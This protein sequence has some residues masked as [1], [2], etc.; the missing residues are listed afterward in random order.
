MTA[1]SEA[2]E[3]TQASAR[4]S[5]LLPRSH[6]D[7]RHLPLL[8]QTEQPLIV[9][10]AHLTTPLDDLVDWSPTESTGAAGGIRTHDHRITSAALYQL[11]YGSKG[12]PRSI[13]VK[14]LEEQLPFRLHAAMLRRLCGIRGWSGAAGERPPTVSRSG[15]PAARRPTSAT[16]GTKP[17]GGR[18]RW[19][20]SC[21]PARQRPGGHRRRER[22]RG[23]APSA[24][25]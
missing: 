16:G 14:R 13:S 15:L 20:P 8:A 12:T 21:D 19:S 4:W 22:L 7:R 5:L 17:A 25:R 9:L 18:H 1:G 24:T 10:V 23:S 2:V 6:S 3:S 11:S